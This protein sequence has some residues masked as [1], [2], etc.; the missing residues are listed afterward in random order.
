MAVPHD[1]TERLL[2]A[3]AGVGVPVSRIGAFA[4][5][6][7]DVAVENAPPGLSASAGGWSH[8]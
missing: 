6:E 1:R 7:P 3:A 5:G 8:F 4:A 2:A